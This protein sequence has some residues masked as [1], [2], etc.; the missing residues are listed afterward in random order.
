MV[1]VNQFSKWWYQCNTDRLLFKANPFIFVGMS[2][3]AA[4]A[5]SVTVNVSTWKVL[6]C[7]YIDEPRGMPFYGHT[8]DSYVYACTWEIVQS[9][10]S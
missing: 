10:M 2:Q 8:G 3:G 5:F 6:E 7:A 9:M 4:C 1:E